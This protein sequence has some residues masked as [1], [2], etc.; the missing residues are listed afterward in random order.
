M[1]IKLLSIITSLVCCLNS[2]GQ[3]PGPP[4]GKTYEALTGQA[5]KEMTDGGCMI[6]TYC[7]LHFKKDSVTVTYR[8]NA[9]CTPKEK[10]KNYNHLYDNLSKTYKWR[11]AK[12]VITITGF[13]DFG[14]LS[15]E[16]SKLTGEYKRTNRSTE[17]IEVAE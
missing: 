11:M 5:C 13:D 15:L 14:P 8:I 9:A 6:Y 2:V 10:E 12:N 1:T 16:D 7:L 17:F 4:A 3:P